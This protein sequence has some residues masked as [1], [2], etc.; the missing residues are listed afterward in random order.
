MD[1]P[2]CS[3]R[4]TMIDGVGV[5]GGSGHGLTHPMPRSARIVT[6]MLGCSSRRARLW[7]VGAFPSAA[8]NTTEVSPRPSRRAAPKSAHWRSASRRLG[9][10]AFVIG[11]PQSQPEVPTMSTTR[12]TRLSVALRLTAALVANPVRA[13]RPRPRGDP[14]SH[15]QQ[16]RQRQ[17]T[18][19][20]GHRLV[21]GTRSGP[22]KSASASPR[23]RRRHRAQSGRPVT[24]RPT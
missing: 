3:V 10:A 13:F 11:A 8:R 6:E 9:V 17:G 22:S 14:N 2:F 20:T 21:I 19:D 24:Q 18:T 7:A 1:R 5:R 23:R 4:V 12:T 16:E 15:R